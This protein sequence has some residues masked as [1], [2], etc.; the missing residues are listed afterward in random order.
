MHIEGNRTKIANG[1]ISCHWTHNDFL[2]PFRLTER[3]R[4]KKNKKQVF[5]LCLLAT[6]FG[7][8][9]PTKVIARHL[10]DLRWLWSGSHLHP[11]FSPFDHPTQVGAAGSYLDFSSQ[12]VNCTYEL[13]SWSIWPPNANLQYASSNCHYFQPPAPPFAQ[14]FRVQVCMS[15]IFLYN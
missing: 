15:T 13:T 3:S 7:H 4:I 10:S 1:V 14:A 8:V 9:I 2:F 11:S 12:L 6:P 5:N